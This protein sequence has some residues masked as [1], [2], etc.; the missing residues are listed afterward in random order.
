MKEKPRLVFSDFDGTLT[1]G[2]ELKPVI[3][4]ILNL[5]SEKNVP[6]VIVTGRSKSWAHFF[7]THFPTI[8]HVISEGGGVLS[9]KDS[10][11]SKHNL[12][13]RVLISQN[14]VTRLEH[15]TEA[16][17]KKFPDLLLSADSFGRQTDRAIELS[18]IMAND[19]RANSIKEF[20]KAENVNFSTS[21]V[22][23][24]YWCGDFS[25]FGAVE[26]FLRD[27]TDI[28]DIESI[29]FGDALNDQSM[30]KSFPFSVGVSNLKDFED[31]LEHKPSLILEG[32]ENEGP[33][34][35]MNYLSSVLK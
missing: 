18:Y 21:N 25:K 7:L 26:I 20:M 22:H 31:L 27:C 10:D 4:D 11:G 14:E 24:N 17:I 3:F 8:H 12:H 33:F 2:Q 13:D 9:S 23:L 15:F 35:V 6:L 32:A 19:E 34:G 28:T 16:L 1:H 5:L 29:Y 30:F